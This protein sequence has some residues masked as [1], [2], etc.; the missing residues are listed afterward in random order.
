M[1]TSQNI[2]T[3]VLIDYY[4]ANTMKINARFKKKQ[5]TINTPALLSL[6]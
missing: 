5:K 2:S 4:R 3:V 1:V 6:Y